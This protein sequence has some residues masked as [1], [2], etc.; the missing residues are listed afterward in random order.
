M[1]WSDTA[2]ALNAAMGAAHD[3]YDEAGSMYKPMGTAVPLTDAA[4]D[5]QQEPYEPGDQG[6]PPYMM[7]DSY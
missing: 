1:D 2:A 5:Q 6:E 4:A 3:R 7:G